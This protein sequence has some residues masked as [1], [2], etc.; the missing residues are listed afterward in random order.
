MD[1]LMAQLGQGL[2]DL[3]AGEADELQKVLENMMTELMSKEILYEPL[4]ELH[5]K[6]HLL[7]WRLQRAL[8]IPA[9]QFPSYLKEHDSTLSADDK[10]RYD[11]QY[12]CV[13]KLITIFED[14][15]YSD[16]DP[17]KGAQVVTLMTEVRV[18]AVPP[19]YGVPDYRVIHLHSDAEPWLAT[20][21]HHGATASGPRHGC[22]RPAKDA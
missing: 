7:L 4:K 13:S 10:K 11:A 16:S 18:L 15:S 14:P 2:N 17:E 5:D 3:D 20:R 6:V 12:T 8:N 1:D 22:G 9:M 21:G 19:A